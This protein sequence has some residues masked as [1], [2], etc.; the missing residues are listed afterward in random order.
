MG[1]DTAE[2]SL[3]AMRT[4]FVINKDLVGANAASGD[5]EDTPEIHSN[6]TVK[7]PMRCKWREIYIVEIIN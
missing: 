3:S 2:Q 7:A 6:P 1:D 5:L 4:V